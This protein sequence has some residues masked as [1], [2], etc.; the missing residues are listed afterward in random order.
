M[1]ERT[2]GGV[3]ALGKYGERASG[4]VGQ[5]ESNA[6]EAF[7][8]PRLHPHEQSPEGAPEPVQMAD[9]CG[10]ESETAFLKG[11]EIRRCHTWRL[12]DHRGIGRNGI[13]TRQDLPRLL[14]YLVVE[15]TPINTVLPLS[16]LCILGSLTR[17]RAALPM[18]PSELSP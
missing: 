1:R 5:A 16:F 13:R 14:A 18:S 11:G 6:I 9:A 12:I 4:L 10:H 3:L 7:S 8:K 15:A 17:R 2:N